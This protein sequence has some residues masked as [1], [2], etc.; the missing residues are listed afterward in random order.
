MCSPGPGEALPDVEHKFGHGDVG[1]RPQGLAVRSVE[2]VARVVPV[3][4]SW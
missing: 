4:H 2:Q 3:T 1:P